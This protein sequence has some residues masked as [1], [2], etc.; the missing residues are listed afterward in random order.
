MLQGIAY[1]FLF[2][3]AFGFKYFAWRQGWLFDWLL[4]FDMERIKELY[5]EDFSGLCIIGDHYFSSCGIG[6]GGYIRRA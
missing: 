3:L 5:N 2:A 6:Y 4:A 1:A